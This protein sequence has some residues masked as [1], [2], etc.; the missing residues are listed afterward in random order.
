MDLIKIG[1][2]IAGKRKALNLTQ[3]ELAEKLG[4]SDKSVSKWER[5]VCLPDVSVFE[6]LCGLLGISLNEFLAGEDLREENLILRAEE[7]IIGVARDGKR[8]Q[9]RLKRVLFLV[10]VFAVLAVAF[11]SALLIFPTEV[12]SCIAPVDRDSPE[13]KTIELLAGADG[14]YLFDFT[15][16]EAFDSLDIFISQYSE[17]ELVSKESLG[18]SFEDMRSP[19]SGKI[20]IVP[21]FAEFTV[22]LIVAAEGTKFST[23]LPI[24]DGVD[25]R[26]CFGRAA[27]QMEGE[28]EIRFGSEQGLAALIYGKDALRVVSISELA[29]GSTD[30]VSAND[31]MYLF[32]VCFG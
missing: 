10:L 28:E 30:A 9:K 32:T 1:Q 20:L 26:E 21:D 8:K 14:A 25:G 12:R 4:M 11:L 29:N 13:M 31:H 2:Y 27:T 17:G 5:G 16:V 3:R 18:L 15:A 23:K 6:E 7:N 22:K 24:L 19:Q